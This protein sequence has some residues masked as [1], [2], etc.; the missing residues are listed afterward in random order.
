[1]QVGKPY[2]NVAPDTNT[3]KFPVKALDFVFAFNCTYSYQKAID[4]NKTREIW[5]NQY[6]YLV[7]WE[8]Y[9]Q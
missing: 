4:K 7:Q 8:D 6:N 1:M 3:A 9:P 5:T 2:Y